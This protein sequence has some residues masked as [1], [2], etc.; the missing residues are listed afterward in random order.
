MSLSTY[1]WGSLAMEFIVRLPKRKTRYDCI[2]TWV[3][4]FSRG[5]NLITSKHRETAVDVSGQLFLNFFKIHRFPDRIVSDRDPKYTS[6][7]WI[8]LMELCGVQIKI[9]SSRHPQM[10]GTSEVQVH[11]HRVCNTSVSNHLPG[12][13]F[14]LRVPLGQI[15]VWRCKFRVRKTP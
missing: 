10:D 6:N 7:V 3:E 12:K 8:K 14:R 2:T 4:W 13:Q 9:S 5:V 15:A 11:G 1:F